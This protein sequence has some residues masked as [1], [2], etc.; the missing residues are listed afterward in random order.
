VV[1]PYKK[2]LTYAAAKNTLQLITESYAASYTD[3]RFHMVSPPNLEGGKVKSQKG[4]CVPP[5]TVAA[6]IFNV[7]DQR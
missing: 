6:E 1:K 7:I 2:I 5:Q 3:I 4:E